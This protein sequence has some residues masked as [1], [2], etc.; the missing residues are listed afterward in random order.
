MI[1]YVAGKYSAETTQQRWE[2]T[3][4]A[5]WAGAR[6]E[7]AGG[8]AVVPHLLHYLDMKAREMGIEIPY[9]TWM[10]RALFMLSHCKAMVVLNDSPGVQREIEFAKTHHIPIYQSVEDLI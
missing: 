2:N 3:Q 7:E 6:I 9:E 10:Q 1:V 5:M 4:R 8:H